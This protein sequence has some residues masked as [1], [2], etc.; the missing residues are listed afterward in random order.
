VVLVAFVEV[1]GEDSQ[2]ELGMLQSR[3]DFLEAQEDRGESDIE[4]A[5]RLPVE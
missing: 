5:V 2:Q 3:S 4:V 1:E